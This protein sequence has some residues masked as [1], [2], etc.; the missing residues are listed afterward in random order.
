MLILNIE[1]FKRNASF[2]LD[3]ITK[4]KPMVIFLQEIWLHKFDS[5]LLSKACIDYSF[6]TSTPDMFDSAEDM[7]S[8]TNIVGLSN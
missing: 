8:A 5:G 1:G 4:E 7:I 2:L 6:E 3:L